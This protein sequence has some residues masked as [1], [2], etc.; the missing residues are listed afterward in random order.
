MEILARLE[1]RIE[2]MLMK[3]RGLENDNAELKRRM[4][5]SISALEDENLRLTEELETERA[6]K[7]AVV[8]RIDSLLRKLTEHE[9]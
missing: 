2:E 1:S 4:E 8:E 3:I 7:E 5:A 6:G 9:E